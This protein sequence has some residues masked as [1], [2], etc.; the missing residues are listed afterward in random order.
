MSAGAIRKKSRVPVMMLTAKVEE[1]DILKGL[2]IGADDYVTKPFKSAAGGGA[3]GRHFSA[4]T[5]A[6]A[7]P[8]ADE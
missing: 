7:V 5:L 1:E 8:I 4:G 6:E 2:G 3:G